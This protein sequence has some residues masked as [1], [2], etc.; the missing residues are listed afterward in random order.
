MNI[1]ASGFKCYNFMPN[2]SQ[3]IKMSVVIAPIVIEEKGNTTLISYACSMGKAC[4]N[5][6]CIYAKAKVEE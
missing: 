4:F 1:Y 5:P 6:Y 2:P 3:T